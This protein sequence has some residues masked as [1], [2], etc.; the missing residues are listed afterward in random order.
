MTRP[1]MA[2]FLGMLLA[3]TAAG[4]GA[5]L[6][7]E[8]GLSLWVPE[9]WVSEEGGDELSLEAPDG[10]VAIHLVVG[11]EGEV[12]D[13][14]SVVLGALEAGFADVELTGEG[15]G[16]YRNGL[17]LTTFMGT[18]TEREEGTP[19]EWL[20]ALAEGRGTCVIFGVGTL[21]GMEVH[22]QTVDTVLGSVAPTTGWRESE[23][24]G[25]R[26]WVADGWTAVDGEDALQVGAPDGEVHIAVWEA[27]HED[28][29]AAMAAVAEELEREVSEV[30]VTTEAEW[31]EVHGMP[32]V[33]YQGTG[34]I[35]G[36]PVHWTTTL[37][38]GNRTV[39]VLELGTAEGMAAHGE[40]LEVMAGSVRPLGWSAGYGTRMAHGEAGL[41]LYRLEEWTTAVD[42]DT[43]TMTAPEGRAVIHLQAVD[44]EDLEG[45]AAEVTALLSGACTDIE[46][47]DPGADVVNG[48]PVRVLSGTA[49]WREGGE[50]V[51]WWAIV[52]DALRPVVLLGTV[53]EVAVDSHG[54]EIQEVL[55]SVEMD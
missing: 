16:E 2:W 45:A 9:T 36:T 4:A 22:R 42:G 47:A 43:A 15:E 35:E 41:H 53:D 26:L 46:A 25:V 12:E 28:L 23:T 1:G 3:A 13:A 5:R 49:R 19:V 14:R 48:L 27:N 51:S 24:A 39:I 21:E 40:E 54:D 17:D 55:N 6:H 37:I 31:D 30:E 38:A 20:A 32:T 44:A 8:T 33:S 10:T 11:G 52:V 34:D 7:E 18:A 50:G 29:E